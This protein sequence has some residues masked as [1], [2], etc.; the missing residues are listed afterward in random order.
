MCGRD[1]ATDFGVEHM[2]ETEWNKV[3]AEE[4]ENELNSP[5]AQQPCQHSLSIS[6]A[7]EPHQRKRSSKDLL[8]EVVAN[9]SSSL[10][11]YCSSVKEY[12][13]T[14]KIKSNHNFLVKRYDFYLVHINL[15][16]WKSCKRHI[17]DIYL[18]W[19]VTF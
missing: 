13:A 15:F 11:E 14:K 9:I 3:M 18:S 19:Y 4:G 17:L 7:V 16:F 1:R 6:Y 12:F 8:I 5:I 2:N 10:K